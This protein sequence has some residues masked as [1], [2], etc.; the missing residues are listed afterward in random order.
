MTIT[1]KKKSGLD[2][3][4]N[5]DVHYDRFKIDVPQ[6]DNEATNVDDDVHD[7]VKNDDVDSE[8]ETDRDRDRGVLNQENTGTAS[9][10][11]M[12]SLP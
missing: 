8:S 7:D 5:S 1:T 4:R 10:N 6:N 12:S 11:S 9:E 2:S 3:C